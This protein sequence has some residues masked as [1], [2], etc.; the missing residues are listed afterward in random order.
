MIPLITYQVIVV[1]GVD[2]VKIRNDC[3]AYYQ[4]LEDPTAPR[5][6]PLDDD[7]PQNQNEDDTV[8]EA[9]YARNWRDHRRPNTDLSHSATSIRFVGRPEDVME[10]FRLKQVEFVQTENPIEVIY[11]HVKHNQDLIE[12]ELEGDYFRYRKKATSLS[13]F[14]LHNGPRLGRVHE[15][16]TLTRFMLVTGWREWSLMFSCLRTIAYC[17]I[18]GALFWDVSCERIFLNE[19]LL[20]I[21]VISC[22]PMASVYPMLDFQRR[23]RSFWFH[24]ILMPHRAR[25]SSLMCA[26]VTLCCTHAAIIGIFR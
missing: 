14:T 23:H 21:F 7:D 13:P 11:E 10:Y 19:R 8:F 16:W 24:H 12:P 4:H 1:G 25:V 20:A 3:N 15:V 17:L 18:V 26:L 22:I 5:S 6:Q 9:N 2:P